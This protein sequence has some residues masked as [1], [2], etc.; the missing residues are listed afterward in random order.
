MVVTMT[1]MITGPITMPRNPNMVMPAKTDSS[2][3]AG[4]SL[5]SLGTRIGRSTLSMLVTT[6]RW[7]TITKMP[8]MMLPNS[9]RP[10][11]NGMV[12]M[13]PPS[14]I[15]ESADSRIAKMKNPSWKPAR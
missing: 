4:S 8:P 1:I 7:K 10:M 15:T 12:T 11:P 13:P 3:S 2:I 6:T 5:A 14:G 9:I